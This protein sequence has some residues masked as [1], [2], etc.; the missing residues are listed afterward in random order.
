[1]GLSR[2]LPLKCLVLLALPLNSLVGAA[3]EHY[4]KV[5]SGGYA[6][7]GATVTASKGGLKV[8]ATTDGGGRYTLP[9]LEPGPWDLHVEMPCF[10]TVGRHIVI[11]ATPSADDFVLT[12]SPL[13]KILASDEKIKLVPATASAPV[14]TAPVNHGGLSSAAEQDPNEGLLVNGSSNNA[15]SSKFGTSPALGN[16]RPRN[17]AV[18]T[19]GLAFHFGNSALD[20]KPYSITGFDIPKPEYSNLTGI[21]TLGGPIQIPHLLRHGP[22]F[23]LVYEWTRNNNAMSLSGLMPTTAQRHPGFALDPVAQSLLGLYPLPNLSGSANYNYQRSVL[24]GQHVDNVELR[25]DKTM[26][27]WGSLSG[28]FNLANQRA[29]Q[30]SIFDFHDVTKTLGLNAHVDWQHKV[31]QHAYATL[32]YN[33]SR[34]RTDLRPNFLNERN[35]SGDAGMKGNLQD[36]RDWGPPTLSFST[37]IASLTDAQSQFNRNQTDMVSYGFQEYRQR[38]NIKAGGDFRRQQFNYLQ[39]LDPRGTFTF[40]GA[41]FGSDFSDFLH[42]V[43]D[44]ASIA[45]GNADK[46]LRQ[47]VTD[48]YINDDLHLMPDLTVNLGLRWDYSAPIYELKDRLVNLDIAG[49]FTR[50]APVLASDP[51]GLVTGRSYPRSL[52]KSDFGKFQPRIGVSWRPISGSSTVVRAGYGV[53]VDTSVYQQIAFQLSQQSP[54]SYTITAN[55]ADCAQTLARGPAPC[56][57]STANTFAVDPDFRMGYAQTWQLGIQQDLPWSL[58]MS[59]TY[60]G[61]RG[62]HGVQQ[63]LPNTYAPGAPNPCPSCPVGF[64]YETSNGTSIRHAGFLSLR[65]RLHSGFAAEATY[66][67]SKSID[68]DSVLGGQGSLATGTA[69]ANLGTSTI[70]QNWRNLSAERSL[71]S[72]DQR[73]LLSL[74]GQYTTGTGATGGTLLSGWR[75]QLYKEWTF[76]MT[77]SAGTGRPLTPVYLAALNGTAVTGLIRPDVT[78]ISVYSASGDR[79][80]NPAAFTSPHPGYFGNAGRYSIEGPAQLTLGFSVSRTFRLSRRFNLEIR[81]D[82]SNFT[83]HVTFSGYNTTI[84]PTLESPTFGLPTQAGAMRTVNITGRLRF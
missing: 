57:T 16:Q 66:T 77:L 69:T 63:F 7:P 22:N 21:A 44:T 42:G 12:M 30:T 25:L 64:L 54:L 83:N 62:A 31:S 49:G 8:V 35:I 32:G 17:I 19:G 71:S 27:G 6:V 11:Q 37:G 33:F 39:Q 4:G 75:G 36:S 59:A 23:S 10:E 60:N 20:A 67:F 47:S 26:G 48:L 84:S 13:E 56:S 46:Y 72:F 41:A 74:S 24:N 68:S 15:S 3:A 2:H 52:M 50:E 53:Y 76:A 79:H 58:Q 45:Y 18:Y 82:A 55:N 61:L 80:L 28:V 1:M 73:H 38:H 65:R 43:P 5:T 70:A 40:T 29:D 14:N 34:A 9:N 81:S 51:V 78:G